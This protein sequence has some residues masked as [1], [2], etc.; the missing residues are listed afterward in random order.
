VLNVGQNRCVA[1]WNR[2]SNVYGVVRMFKLVVKRQLVVSPLLNCIQLVY[3]VGVDGLLVSYVGAGLDPTNF[4][5]F[6]PLVHN[7]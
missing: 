7:F 1:V 4:I 3:L 5:H 2:V 6:F